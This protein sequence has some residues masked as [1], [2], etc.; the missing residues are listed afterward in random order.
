M[1]ERERRGERERNYYS[2]GPWRRGWRREE[3]AGKAGGLGEGERQGRGGGG[4]TTVQALGGGGGGGRRKRV[5]LE[6]LGETGERGRRS[7][8]STGPWRRGW[9]REEEAGKAGGRGGES[10]GEK[11]REI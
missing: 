10:E 5:R 6:G 2:T 7:Y 1:G 8:Y 4:T 11:E 9:M 3:E